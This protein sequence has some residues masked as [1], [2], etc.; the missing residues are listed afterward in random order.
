MPGSDDNELRL[1]VFMDLRQLTRPGL[2]SLFQLGG[3][4]V[5]PAVQRFITLNPDQLIAAACR[6]TGL[7]DFG[8]DGFRPALRELLHSCETEADLNLVG[9]LAARSDASRILR[10]RLRLQE[11][12]R[13]HPEI[14]AE[15]IR[16]PLVVV[17][18]PRSGTTLLH[19][20][21]SQDPANRVPLTWESMLPSPPPERA[22]YPT[23]RRIEFAE[24]QVGWFLRIAPEFQRIHPV[25]ARLAEECVML[26]S[27]SFA[28]YQ[29][30]TMYR[31]PSYQAWMER[32]D[33]RGAYR[34]HRQLL[35]QLQWRCPG[36]RWVLKAP[37]HLFALP[38]LVETYPD[39]GLIWTHRSPADV[40]PS[41]ASLVTELR[42]VFSDSVDPSTVGPEVSRVWKD[43]L[44]RGLQALDRGVVPANR[45]QH[46]GYSELAADPVGAVRRL[47]AQFEIPFTAEFESR[48]RAFLQEFPRGRFGRHEYSMEA[49]GLD[50]EEERMRYRDYCERFAV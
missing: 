48:L 2:A 38:A 17:G 28:S 4:F 33:L 46:V 39:V 42:R 34:I 32:Q 44:Q 7:E 15:T 13:R 3:R 49:F 6:R 40:I 30:D 45:V 10:N 25:G 47:Y 24:R 41:L 8:D 19:R 29:F 23:D 9:R 26:M 35:Q 36:E 11:D 22:T 37:N 14:A 43:G 27:H 5:G 50:P 18:L 31:I 12:R 16:R 21:L 1:T 20:M